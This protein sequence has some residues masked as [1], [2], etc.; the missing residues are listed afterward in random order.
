MQ[1][2]DKGPRD[3]NSALSEAS[4]RGGWRER[5]KGKTEE[6]NGCKGWMGEEGGNGEQGNSGKL[7]Q[8]SALQN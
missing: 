4:T 1:L 6:R 7:L 5:G 2:L 8:M 3:S